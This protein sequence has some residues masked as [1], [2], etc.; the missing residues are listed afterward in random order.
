MVVAG[1]VHIEASVQQ[2]V[3]VRLF[4]CEL[5]QEGGVVV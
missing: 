2:V 3:D 4:G 5:Q 1:C